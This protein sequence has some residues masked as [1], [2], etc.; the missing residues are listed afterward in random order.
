MCR[1]PKPLRA[2]T[3][4]GNAQLA[5][6]LRRQPG[7]RRADPLLLEELVRE[8]LVGAARDRLGAGHEHDRAAQLVARLGE[9][10]VVEV[11]QRHDQPHVVQLDEVAQR[12]DV[13]GV[14]DARHE[15]PAVGV[16]ERGRELVDVGGDRRRAGRRKAV[17]M[18]TRCP[19]QVKR[20]AVTAAEGTRG[21]VRG[22]VSARQPP[23][24]PL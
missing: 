10:E 1:E 14:V 8:V 12:L 20:T 4:T 22:V 6:Q 15:R 7:R 13:A 2:F 18:S 11:G 16:V 19:A 17:T 21:R 5:G 24:G 9:H 23:V 3:S